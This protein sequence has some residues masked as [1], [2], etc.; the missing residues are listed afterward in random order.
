MNEIGKRAVYFVVGAVCTPLFLV[1]AVA[2]A[3][4]AS[5]YHSPFA[6]YGASAVLCVIGLSAA[7][8]FR[9]AFRSPP[10]WIVSPEKSRE[11][12]KHALKRQVVVLAKQQVELSEK[13][14]K[15]SVKTLKLTTRLMEMEKAEPCAAPNGGPAEQLDDSGVGGG[16][17]SVS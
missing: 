11:F 12:E 9:A 14:L 13:K 16:P 3:W 7:S 15:L 1:L 2:I 5:Q 10:W 6:A 4:H 17:P 8:A